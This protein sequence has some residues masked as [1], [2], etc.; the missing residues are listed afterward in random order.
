MNIGH[1]E[2]GAKLKVFEEHD[3][4]ALGEEY[5][6]TFRNFESGKLFTIHSPTLYEHYEKLS[7]DA[8]L[9]ISFMTDAYIHTFTGQAVEKQR[10]SG[11]IL[12]EQLTEIVTANR[13][14]I[15]RDEFRVSVRVF[16]LAEKRLD[17]THFSKPETDADMTDMTYDVS[18]DGVCVISNTLL[19]SKH[20]PYYLLE[21]SLSKGEKDLF[22][23]PAK[24]VR[25]SNYHRTKIGRYDYGFQFIF[26]N[27]PDEKGRLSRAILN[28]KLSK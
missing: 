16:G 3:G 4:R 8:C 25:R 22:L 17:D 12:I 11:M 24:L 18:A 21:L 20:D 13:R 14:K 5:D 19:G 9:N 1:I 6:A 7:S 27:L 10:S 15:D 2:R 26:D 28:K 23:L